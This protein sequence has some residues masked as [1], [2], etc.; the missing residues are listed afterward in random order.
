MKQIYDLF[1]VI[2]AGIG[3]CVGRFLGGFDGFL[4]ALIAFV[5]IDYI[6][7]IMAAILEK[8]L[9]SELGF[10]GIFKKIMIF[11]LVCIGHILDLY[12]IGTGSTFR[13][14]VIFFYC[15]NEGLSIIENACRIGLPVPEKIKDILEQIQDKGE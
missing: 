8:N 9:S 14:A 7:G 15:S 12:L 3:G 13:T 2:I 11:L 5:I 6:T 4:Y 10:K 1:R